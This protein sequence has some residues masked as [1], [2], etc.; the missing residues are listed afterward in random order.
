MT[1]AVIIFGLATSHGLNDMTGRPLGTDFISFWTAGRVA[2]AGPF[3]DAWD[4]VRHGSEQ[5]EIFGPADS[6]A[7]FF[8]PPVYL[9]LC[10]PLGL[11]PY[12]TA[13]AVWLGATGLA[14]RTA[15]VAWA[16]PWASGLTGL[17]ALLAFPAFFS[18][19][20]HGQNA[21]LTTAIFATGGIL[22]GRRP[23]LAGVVLG[24]LVYK[25][26]MAV[27]LPVAFAAAGYWRTF[28]AMGA[29]AL[30]LIAASVLAFGMTSWI[31][32]MKL[33]S[34]VQ[35]TLEHGL[36][37]PGKM[38]S[39]YRSMRLVG[40]GNE[41]G[42]AAQTIVAILV[43]GALAWVVRRY[44]NPEGVVAAAA[45]ATLLISPYM[46]DYDMM[47]LAVPM[48]WMVRA[49]LAHGFRDWERVVLLAAFVL[50]GIARPI[51]MVLGAPIAPFV[52]LLFLA[53]VLQRVVYEGERGT[54]Q[55]S[56][57]DDDVAVDTIPKMA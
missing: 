38:V 3:D 29:S 23:V 42:W 20:G 13:L 36:V 10:W 26:H 45:A 35:M 49:G 31:E 25:P 14:C 24:C 47:L 27:A 28:F 44:R 56:R 46:L 8:Y 19:L 40:F 17:L 37:D 6:F 12:L 48:A 39:V 5:Q 50:P 21:F 51:G 52:M 15:L 41:A 7:A 2:V 16:G 57:A 55:A 34:V 43:L 1:V 53:L 9:F 4:M 18:T 22:L 30:M 33:S 54:D 11:L 32:F